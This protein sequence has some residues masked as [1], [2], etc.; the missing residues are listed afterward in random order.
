MPSQSAKDHLRWKTEPFPAIGK[1]DLLA[2]VK[3]TYI[4]TLVDSH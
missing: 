4:A 1:R 3:K 2:G